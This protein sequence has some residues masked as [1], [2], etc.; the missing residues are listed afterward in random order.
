[1]GG[2][3]LERLF[4]PAAVAV[5]G[6]SEG[7]ESVAGR[8]MRNLIDGG[9]EGRIYPINPKHRTVYGRRCYSAF[10]EVENAVDLAIIATPAPTVHGIIEQCG[11]RGD[12]RALVH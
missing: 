1:M 2:H 12:H 4:S 9:Y 3:F 7:A 5:F 10:G 6:A 11:A 8:V